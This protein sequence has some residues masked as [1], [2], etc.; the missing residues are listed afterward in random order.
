MPPLPANDACWRSGPPLLNQPC[1]TGRWNAMLSILGRDIRLC[2]GI[3]RRE[4]LRIGGL[5]FTG[6]MWS[7]WL[8]ARATAANS[9]P[10]RASGG[11]T[12]GKAKA[13]I[14]IY[15]YGGPSHL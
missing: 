12:F 14:L 4:A 1:F 11:A 9:S 2:D 7:D 15:N 3:N 8:R 6:L 5:G 10:A 13:C